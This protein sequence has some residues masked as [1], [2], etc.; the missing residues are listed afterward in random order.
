ME[1]TR[2]RTPHSVPSPSV[3]NVITLWRQ[4]SSL[5]KLLIVFIFASLGCLLLFQG[6]LLLSFIC[7]VLSGLY[8]TNR[9]LLHDQASYYAEIFIYKLESLYLESKLA[10]E[11][12]QKHNYRIDHNINIFLPDALDILKE[13]EPEKDQQCIPTE[14]ASPSSL[15][16]PSSLESEINSIQLLVIRDFVRSWY[17]EFSYNSQ[18][19]KEIKNILQ[20]ISNEIKLRLSQ[21]NSKL[22][23]TNII[24]LYLDHL[25]SF[26]AAKS[27]Y[28]SRRIHPKTKV[29]LDSKV[30]R[31]DS[32]E[33][34]FQDS[35]KF[36]AALENEEVEL[37][38]L[39]EI[40]T[41][42]TF[43]LL[44]KEITDG[45]C[46][47][48]LLIEVLT[49]KL[50]YP[51]MQMVSEPDWLHKV[52]IKLTS[53]DEVVSNVIDKCEN[54]SEDSFDKTV[55]SEPGSELE[56]LNKTDKKDSIQNEEITGDS[57]TSLAK[58]NNTIDEC[59]TFKQNLLLNCSTDTNISDLSNCKDI[60]DLSS[61]QNCLSNK[62]MLDSLSCST[63]SDIL[64]SDLTQSTELSC[65]STGDS[66]LEKTLVH[67]HKKGVECSLESDDKMQSS[68]SSDGVH[69]NP[70]DILS[71]LSGDKIFTDI[72]SSLEKKGRLSSSESDAELSTS[73]FSLKKL[74]PFRSNSAQAVKKPESLAVS[75]TSETGAP[76]LF[77]NNQPLMNADKVKSSGS[78]L[79][80]DQFSG[81]ESELSPSPVA[82]SIHSGLSD[83]SGS[84]SNL[85]S[86]ESTELSHSLSL[87]STSSIDSKSVDEDAGPSGFFIEDDRRIFQDIAINSTEIYDEQ[88]GSNNQ[89]CLYVIEVMYSNSVINVSL[90]ITLTGAGKS[91]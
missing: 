43:A 52:I 81:S 74:F 34:A 61:Q 80:L 78:F 31:Y 24:K 12:F 2:R 84:T 22:V 51:I 76:K 29:P 7:A 19:L 42:I 46:S 62:E 56:I 87:Q 44:Q 91:G 23:L 37:K 30:K 83:F 17:A 21:Q 18:F 50:L 82:L 71:Y 11:H 55:V 48:N 89:Y 69:H 3:T 54:K 40:M 16:V 79:N 66:T 86:E 35:N 33:E 39:K 27:S 36:H 90:R 88:R 72:K 75:Y 5:Q 15:S 77:L 28:E 70:Q 53:Y 47:R 59:N 1:R 63:S 65:E 49:N 64:P 45:P 85:Y 6:T 57:D 20:E 9:F 25:T 73:K 8:L 38:Y 68:G 58:S 67:S 32:V 41:V 60:P 14:S 13:I 26:R 4:F 10:F